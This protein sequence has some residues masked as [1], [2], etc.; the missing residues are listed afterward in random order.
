MCWLKKTPQAAAVDFFLSSCSRSLFYER[1]FW[2]KTVVRQITLETTLTFLS[3]TRGGG[4]ARFP[5]IGGNIVKRN[6][7]AFSL[8]DLGRLTR[9][10]KRLFIAE[11]FFLFFRRIQYDKLRFLFWILLMFRSN[12]IFNANESSNRLFIFESECT[13]IVSFHNVIK[14]VVVILKEKKNNIYEVYF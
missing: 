3:K 6:T 9:S 14:Y 1:F 4:P 13:I 12:I 2:N 5:I 10:K 11:F 7:H 8:Y